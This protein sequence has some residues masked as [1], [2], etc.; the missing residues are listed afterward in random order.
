M[1]KI[2]IILL[3]L[4]FVGFQADAQDQQYRFGFQLSPNFTW[5]GNNNNMINGNGSNLGL[6]LGVMAER[7]FTS[8]DRYS[9]TMGLGFA[10]N[11]GGTL[12]HEV[13]GDFWTK[14][15][16]ENSPLRDLPDGVN[17]K[18][19][20]QYV[21]I[22]MSLKMR[23]QEFGYFRYFVEP[24]FDLAF[25]TQARGEI[26]DAGDLNME[27][28]DIKQDVNLFNLS[29]HIGAG[30]EYAIGESTSL[31]GGLTFQNGFVDITDDGGTTKADGQE[32]VKEDSKAVI[33]SLTIKLG[34][35]F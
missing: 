13:G 35:M 1:K 17:L 7:Y 19:G 12:L 30:V 27:D 9:L 3:I 11:Q 14:S 20:I 18:Y 31:V 25:R 6:R 15:I 5:I 23:T 24:G 26:S 4:S 33:N 10:F 29:W 32:P 8:N 21:E 28:I 34:I 16:D 2:A 22:P